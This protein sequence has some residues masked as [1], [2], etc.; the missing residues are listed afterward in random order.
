MQLVAIRVGLGAGAIVAPRAMGRVFGVDPA[1]NPVSPY[2]MRLFGIRE[3]YVAWALLRT[4]E[5]DLEQTATSMIPIDS[6]DAIA[7]T[8]A[9]I[10]GYLPP[11]DSGDEHRGSTSWSRT[12]R[13][14]PCQEPRR[15]CHRDNG[16]LTRH[17]GRAA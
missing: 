13:L 16:R 11:A 12:R 7:S 14:A 3:L 4:S 5:A 9:G 6:A 1:T 15:T 8:I 17:L 10:A 2:L